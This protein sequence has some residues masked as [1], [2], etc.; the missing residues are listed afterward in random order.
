M[1]QVKTICVCGA[2]TIGTGIAQLAVQSGFQ[3]ILYDVQEEI[4]RKSRVAMEESWKKLVTKEK[5]TEEEI[6][7]FNHR[8]HLTS[9]IQD[10]VADL[11]IEAVVERAT[12]KIDLF[13]QLESIN[14]YR[15][16]LVSNT[17]SISINSLAAKLEDPFRF[18]GMHFFNPATQM[19]LVEI[20]QGEA[21]SEAVIKQLQQV[22]AKLG[23]TAVICKD[24]PGFIVNRVARHYYLESLWL[25][26]QFDLD[27]ARIDELLEASGFK[28]GAFKL[29][30]LIGVDINDGVTRIIGEALGN[31]KRL[32]ASKIQEKMIQNQELGKKT[33]KGFYNYYKQNQD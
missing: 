2:G 21:T 26:E 4:L 33:G 32:R 8:I 7:A 20:V 29:M 18:A 5:L 13:H 3:T 30:D 1:H 15:S 10:C 12:V 22:V 24:S 25:M 6:I 28:M 23:K 17:S 11:I 31:P 16:I 27:A 14:D 19:K 9:S